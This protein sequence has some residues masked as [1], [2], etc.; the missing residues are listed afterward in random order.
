MKAISLKQPW[1]TLVTQ[2]RKTIET[3]TW[4]TAYRGDL[5]I[6]ASKSREYLVAGTDHYPLGVA[7]AVVELYDC[8]QMR[9]SDERAAECRYYPGAHAWCLRNLRRLPKPFSVRGHL[10][11]FNVEIPRDMASAI[12]NAMASVIR[13]CRICGCTDDDCRQCIE[14]TG[15]PCYWVEPDLCSACVEGMRP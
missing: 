7:L 6:C 3:R 11:L 12:S 15:E 1:A 4:W 5:L 14:K 10:G 2:G 13:C 9:K 8:R